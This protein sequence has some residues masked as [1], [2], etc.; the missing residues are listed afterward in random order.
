MWHIIAHFQPTFVEKS[1][2]SAAR[3]RAQRHKEWAEKRTELVVKPELLERLAELNFVRS[4]YLN[5]EIILI[6]VSKSAEAPV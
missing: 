1:I 2:N 4:K 3:L 5:C 6:V